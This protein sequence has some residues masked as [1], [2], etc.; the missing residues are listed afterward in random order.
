MKNHSVYFVTKDNRSDYETDLE[1]MFRMRYRAA[2]QEMGWHIDIDPAG[3]DIDAFDY[4]DTV[5]ALYYNPDGTV[6][7]CGRLNPTTRPHLMSEVFPDLCIGGVP[8]GPQIWEFSRGLIER[9]GKTQRHFM[10]AW[11]LINQAINEY[12][13]DNDISHVTWLARKRLYSLSTLLWQTKPLGLP[14][15]YEDDAKEYVAAISKFDQKGLINVQNYSKVKHQV[16]HYKTREKSELKW[17]C[18]S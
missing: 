17:S 13:I 10:T 7:A 8:K 11:M 1:D 3:R 15:Y 18:A 14:K 2:V 12:C 9:R 5:Y 16:G 4:P 6:G